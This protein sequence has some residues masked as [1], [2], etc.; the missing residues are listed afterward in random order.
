MSVLKEESEVATG[1]PVFCS[2]CKA[3]FNKHSEVE[4]TK[5][6]QHWTCEFCGSKNE[7]NMEPEEIPKSETVNYILE[8]AA[9]VHDKKAGGLKQDIT[10]VFCVDIS[11]SMCVTEAVQGRFDVAGDK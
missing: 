11:G 10:V 9:Q 5:E 2:S 1:D 4:E 3:I 7:V 6:E 8:A